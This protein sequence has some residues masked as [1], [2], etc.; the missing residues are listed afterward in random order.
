MAVVAGGRVTDREERAMTV[1]GDVDGVDDVDDESLAAE[2][3]V[4]DA[5][6]VDAVAEEQGETA[7]DETRHAYSG[8][9]EDSDAD[10]DVEEYEEAGALFDDPERI[11]L[12]EGGIDDPDGIDD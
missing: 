10:V 6:E 11:A 8:V 9:I 7:F 5:A 3:R 12:L 1:A 2:E 4:A